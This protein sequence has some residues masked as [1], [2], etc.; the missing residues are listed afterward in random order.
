LSVLL[1]TAWRCP[2]LAGFVYAPYA[3]KRVTGEL[4]TLIGIEHLRAAMLLQCLFQTVHANT[5]SIVLLIYQLN[6]RIEY[7]SITA[8]R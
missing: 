4:A 7:K 1:A 2:I 3:G 8:T 5:A 6:T